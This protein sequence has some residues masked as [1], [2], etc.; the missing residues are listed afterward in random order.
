MNEIFLRKNDIGVN[1]EYH[2]IGYYLDDNKRYRIY[3]DFV[4]DKNNMFGIRIMVD[5]ENNSEYVRLNSAEEKNI[6]EKY[7]NEIMAYAQSNK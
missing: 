5:L 3:T 6:V 7:N 2:V 1:I 4:T